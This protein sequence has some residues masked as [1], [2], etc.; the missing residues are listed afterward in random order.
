MQEPLRT[1]R[2]LADLIALAIPKKYHPKKIH[3]ATKIFQALRI[4]VNRELDNLTRLLTDGPKLLKPGARFCIITFHS[5]EDRIVKQAFVKSDDYKVLTRK[6][7][8]PTADE[9]RNNSRSR[10]AK[11]RVAERL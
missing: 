9:V 3:V 8:L 10:S 5:L 1:T 4:A 2:Q 6:P 11:L 7:V